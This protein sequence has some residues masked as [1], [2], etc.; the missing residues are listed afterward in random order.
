MKRKN[1]KGIT[2]IALIITIIIMLIL[3]GVGISLTIG[4]DGLFKTAKY[5]V[6]KWNNET[7]K[8]QQ[9]FSNLDNLLYGI[10]SFEDM[11]K[12]CKIDKRYTLEDLVNNKDGILE[13]VLS[14]SDAVN[15]LLSH[16]DEYL[17]AF[18][19]S[20]IAT[21]MLVSKEKPRQKLANNELWLN[22]LIEKGKKIPE[23]NQNM[24]AIP[25]MI[26]NTEPSGTI[27]ESI[28]HDSRYG[29]PWT[30]F[31]GDS[32][33]FWI[34]PS[35]TSTVPDIMPF[36]IYQFDSIC[37]IYRI[38]VDS[39]NSTNGSA[40]ETLEIYVSE[41]ETGEDSWIKVGE[42]EYSYGKN[43]AGTPHNKIFELDKPLKVR[44]IKVNSLLV[45]T[46]NGWWASKGIKEVRVYGL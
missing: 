46:S 5:A 2:L 23:F 10:T 11:L 34:T 18:T 44:R 30:A 19:D 38:D 45:C 42:D 14:N 37:T 22:K 36:F 40:T 15:Y 33:T 9:K 8:E 21:V 7:E 6:N 43:T 41:K 12:E 1:N 4:E 31:D 13:K 28:E 16:P 20:E 24:K 35:F 27:T 39:D 26:T 25:N 32:S 29:G 3:A 17:E